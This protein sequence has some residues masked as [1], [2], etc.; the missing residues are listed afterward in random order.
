MNNRQF[1]FFGLLTLISVI[2]AGVWLYLN[3]EVVE[4][5][6]II[7]ESSEAR[8][9]PMLAAQRLLEKYDYEVRT[10]KDRGLFRDLSVDSIGLLWINDLSVIESIEE[11]TALHEWVR[12]GGNLITG[13]NGPE[14]FD[15]E[16]IAAEFLLDY[17]ISAL[18]SEPGDA[19]EW[20]EDVDFQSENATEVLD[21]NI[22]GD[23][24]LE[25]TI[26]TQYVPYLSNRFDTSDINTTLNTEYVLQKSAELGHI[27][28]LSN[29][30]ALY[31]ENFDKENLGYLWL[32]LTK[33]VENKKT[34]LIY[35]M[36]AQTGM[37]KFIWN[38]FTLPVCMLGLVLIAFLRWAASRLGPVEQESL[39][40]KHN[41]I[42]H[43]Q[44]RGEFWH[45][46][47]YTNKILKEVQ[48]EA[49]LHLAKQRGEATTGQESLE[50]DKSVVTKQAAK[51]LKC[52]RTGAERVLFSEARNDAELLRYT[53]QLQKLIHQIKFQPIQTK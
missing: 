28:V 34:W 48:V 2:V 10:T 4:K 42:A 33:P 9:N 11:K 46:H 25:V 13:L 32:W 14:A 27:T 7:E 31:S 1:P 3:V 22:E 30:S 24:Q 21:L 23:E 35:R 16:S 45:K 5:E 47:K 20:Y 26:S 40:N 44:A 37:M 50:A 6:K 36:N 18:S 49:R 52:S 17:G 53:Q 12:A 41:L 38:R 51:L 29:S 19:F 15:S 43:L 8:K 39:A